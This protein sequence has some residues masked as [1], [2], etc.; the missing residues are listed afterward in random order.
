M[1]ESPEKMDDFFN[2]RAS[3]Y[4]VQQIKNIDGGDKCYQEIARYI[5]SN[6]KALLD[7]GCGT[8]LELESIFKKLS[9][10]EVTC[11]DLANKMLE[12]LAQKYSGHSINLIN[13]NYLTADL[14]VQKYDV[15]ISIMSFHH[16]IHPVKLKLYSNIFQCLKPN[17]I[18][19]E[20]DYMIGSNDS[21]LEEHYLGEREKLQSQY[22][23]TEGL[24]H[25]DIP[26]TIKHEILLLREAGF[27]SVKQVW[28]IENNIMISA[29]K[30]EKK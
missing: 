28:G 29:T 22:N 7:L 10:V 4:D 16:L 1:N 21:D 26:F 11:V 17:G 27:Q 5:P 24:Y 12:K 8:G 19:V 25:Y 14:G 18:F 13:D 20:C 15:A 30:Q 2:T 9:T 3:I 6:A 23:L